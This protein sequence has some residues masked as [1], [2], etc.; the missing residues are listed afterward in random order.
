MGVWSR[1]PPLSEPQSLFKGNACRRVGQGV[2]GRGRG[3]FSPCWRQEVAAAAVAA[4]LRE[5]SR[6]CVFALGCTG[7]DAVLRGPLSPGFLFF[8]F[9]FPYITALF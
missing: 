9:F 4:A 1:H 3:G 5:G 7:T 8:F 2:G 6:T